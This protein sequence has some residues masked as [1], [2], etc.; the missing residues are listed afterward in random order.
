MSLNKK[1]YAEFYFLA[2]IRHVDPNVL[3]FV[4]MLILTIEINRTQQNAYSSNLPPPPW[5][6]DKNLNTI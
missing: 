4:F 6:Q 1:G 5:G 2:P 3:N